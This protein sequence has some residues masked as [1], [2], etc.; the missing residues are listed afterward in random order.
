MTAAELLA[1]RCE[2]IAGQVHSESRR[3]F[4]TKWADPIR[5]FRALLRLGQLT[6]TREAR[7]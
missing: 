3:V 7:W 4:L 1:L 5:R 6:S 2:A